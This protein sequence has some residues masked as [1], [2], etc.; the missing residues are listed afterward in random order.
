MKITSET[1]QEQRDAFASWEA[2]EP[3]SWRVTPENVLPV[4]S[5]VYADQAARAPSEA[6]IRANAKVMYEEERGSHWAQTLN[7]SRFDASKLVPSRPRDRTLVGLAQGKSWLGRG[8]DRL[9]SRFA[10]CHWSGVF[11]HPTCLGWHPNTSRRPSPAVLIGE[12]Y[13]LSDLPGLMGQL[14]EAELLSSLLVEVSA[15]SHY[16]PSRTF[17]VRMWNRAC[18]NR[19]CY[20]A[21]P[22]GAGKGML[23]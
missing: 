16:Y 21:D 18:W 4:I 7:R 6:D 8:S 11:D 13:S 12:P 5:L 15:F 1:I 2:G 10:L 14:A 23:S 19:A 17:S 3:H 20:V 9:R 22:P